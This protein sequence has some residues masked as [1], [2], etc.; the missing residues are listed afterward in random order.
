MMK[1]TMYTTVN[2]GAMPTLLESYDHD[3]Q[4]LQLRV[5]ID[6]AAS[7]LKRRRL[8]RRHMVDFL[9]NQLQRPDIG[10]D[11]LTP[12]FI[13]DFA[14]F[15]STRRRL[16]GGTVWLACQ[17]L[18]GVVAQ[19]CQRGVIQSNPFY[20]FHISKNIRERE[21]LTE[22]ELK[23]L[24]DHAFDNERHAFYR[25][26]FVFSALTGMA[27]ID[28]CHLRSEDIRDINGEPWIQARRHK[29]QTTFYV[30]LL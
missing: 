5:G 19:A 25:D 26:V 13:S 17:H 3:L 9:T 16:R 2:A 14:T 20:N 27:F 6:R 12:S 30:K 15:L 11:E 29:T 28:I 1:T 18:K 7:T 23:Q 8:L 21:Y 22:R 10:L 24:M 4:Q